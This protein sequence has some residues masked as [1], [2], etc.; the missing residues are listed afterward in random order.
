MKAI[1]KDAAPFDFRFSAN[2]NWSSVGSVPGPDNRLDQQIPLTVTLGA[3]Y[4]EDKFSAGASVA[5]RAGGPVR[6]SDE[7]FLRQYGRRDVEAYWLV[8]VRTGLQVR[9]SASNL[10]GEDNR[11]WSRYVDR[12]GASETR[13]WSPGSAR[14]Q[15]N[16]EMKF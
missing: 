1:D 2:R 3:D 7:Q 15:A 16:V 9:L 13:N 14:L 12:N 4:R 10:L 6:V 8:K 11:Y 5:Y